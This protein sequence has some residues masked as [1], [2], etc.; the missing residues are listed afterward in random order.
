VRSVVVGQRGVGKSS[1]LDR[2]MS[3]YEQEDLP[4]RCIDLDAYIEIRQ[5]KKITDIFSA[6]GEAAFRKL[7]QQAFQLIDEDTVGFAGDVIVAVGGGFQVPKDCTWEVVWLRRPTDEI[8]KVFLDRPPLVGEKRRVSQR[9]R[10]FSKVSDWQLWL[11][12]GQTQASEAEKNLWFGRGKTI[13]PAPAVTLLSAVF[14]GKPIENFCA[15]VLHLVNHTDCKIELRD[16]LLLK[17]EIDFARQ[18]VPKDRQLNSFRK[19]SSLKSSFPKDLGQTDVALEIGG[20]DK[21]SILSLHNRKPKESLNQALNRLEKSSAPKQLLKA[22]PMVHSFSELLEGHRWQLEDCKRRSFLPRSKDGSWQWYRMLMSHRQQLNFQ[23]WKDIGVGDQPTAMS[24]QNDPGHKDE[25]A[26]ILG[27]PVIHSLTPQEHQ[28][29]FVEKGLRVVPIKIT[30]ADW[31]SGAFEILKELG[32]RYAAITSPLKRLAFEACSQTSELASQLQ[33]VN[34]IKCADGDWLGENTDFVGL[35]HL[36]KMCY[37]YLDIVI[38]GGG[39]TLTAMQKALPRAVS[40]SARTAKPRN[41]AQDLVSPQVVIWGVG[42]GRQIDCKWPQ[43][44]WQPELVLDLNYTQ[45][46]PGIEYAQRCGAKYVSGLEMFRLQAKAQRE[47]WM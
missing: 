24:W 8:Q 16:D 7:E 45:D 34:T 44:A 11:Q 32:L 13:N 39:G 10:L 41:K 17:E 40:Y 21:A 12:E 35:S 19:K 3:Y 15:Q 43:R 9:S 6:D 33:S 29:F 4:V 22:A 30:E 14:E 25:F 46:S 31:K 18:M 36:Q 37:G 2:L 26:A 1:F 23:R 47:F 5:Q 27:N 42:R 38:W 20:C 28:E